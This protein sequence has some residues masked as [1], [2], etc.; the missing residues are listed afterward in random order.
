MSVMLRQYSFTKPIGNAVK[1]NNLPPTQKSAEFSTMRM[2]VFLSHRSIQIFLPLFLLTVFCSPNTFAQASKAKS[3]PLCVMTYNLRFANNNPGEEWSKRR[4]LVRKVIEDVSPDV[5]GTQEGIWRQVRDLAA[6]LKD[7]EWVG[8]GRDGGSHGEF[9]A[10]FY[11][12]DRLE[13]IEFDHFWLSD[14]PSLMGSKTWGPTLA[15]MVTW[16]RFRDLKTKQEFYFFNTHF[17]HQ[18]QPAREKSAA[19]LRQRISTLDTNLPILLVG[20][21]NA[22]ADKNRAYHILTEDGF[23]ADTWHT[24]RER[25]NEGIGTFNGFEAIR[26][27]GPRIDWILARG[28]VAADKAEIVTYSQKRQFPSDHFPVVTRL[29][30]GE[31]K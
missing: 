28:K 29:T 2:N 24:A 22:A 3:E 1:C 8:L 15:R 23:F 11:R 18:V 12:R 26:P 21:F 20:D 19:L 5:M 27:N 10:V 6:D 13:P 14:T 25:K 9:M 7:Y 17:D 4:P 16:L 31:T 30:L